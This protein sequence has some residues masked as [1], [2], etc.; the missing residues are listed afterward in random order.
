M[1]VPVAHPLFLAVNKIQFKRKLNLYRVVY[2]DII[3]DEF[4]MHRKPIY[5]EAL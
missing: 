5:I 4:I 3:M 2:G 1:Q